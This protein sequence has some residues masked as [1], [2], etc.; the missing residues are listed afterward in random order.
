MVTTNMS[1]WKGI[2]LVTDT[3]W[4]DSGKGK[5]VD[6]AASHSDMVIKTNGGANAGH[7]VVNHLGE[8]KLHLVPS[9]IFHKNVF[10]VI[11][12]EIVADPF[13]LVSEIEEL[14][15]KGIHISKNNLLISD[16]MHL[17]M[18][19]H[20]MRDT[21]KEKAR[22]KVKIGTTGR[23]IGPTYADRADRVGLRMKDL[24]SNDF[25]DI[26]LAEAK[27]QEE[28]TRLMDKGQKENTKYYDTKILLNDFIHVKKI[29]KPFAGNAL[30]KIWKYQNEKKTIIGEAGQGALLDISLGGYPYVTSSHPGASGFSL[31]T[32]IQGR[33]MKRVVGVTKAYTT[34]VGSGPMPTELKGKIGIHLQTKGQEVGATTG[35]TRRC[36]WL[37]CVAVKYGARTT[38]VTDVALTK[39]DILDELKEIKICVGYK[40]KGK[41]VKNLT[42]FD[43]DEVKIAKP[44]YETFPGWQEDITKIKSFSDLPKNAKIYISAIEKLLDLPVSIVS[45]GPSREQTIYR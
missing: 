8:F 21:L 31:A 34:R 9:G 37:D 1:F 6:E 12:T 27:W 15:K 2:T 17:V 23:G 26:F 10:C 44:V 22:G 38:G 16:T 45:V 19:W 40:I 7:T 29:L 14:R 43:T 25:K 32:G 30:L 5:I 35:R 20:K 18:P 11:S 13:A 36:G 3:A 33:E 24:F 28:L 42:S 4:G 41:I 39:L